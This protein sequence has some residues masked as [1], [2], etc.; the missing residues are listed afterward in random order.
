MIVTQYSSIEQFWFFPLSLQT[1][2]S[3]DVV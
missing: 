2:A 1:I 3:S